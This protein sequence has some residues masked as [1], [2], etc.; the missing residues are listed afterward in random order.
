[1]KKMLALLLVLGMLLVNN[2]LSAQ[3]V[4]IIQQNV[5][6]RGCNLSEER[7]ENGLHILTCKEP[8]FQK[9]E[10]EMYLKSK[11]ERKVVKKAIKEVKKRISK[12]ALTGN[13][14][15][16]NAEV[17]YE[18]EDIFNMKITIEYNE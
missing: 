1:M 18:A 12:D 13:F 17:N 5:G 7:F 9:C 10:T 8:G 16:L 4:R 14:E 11:K 3:T 15:M 6:P 2:A